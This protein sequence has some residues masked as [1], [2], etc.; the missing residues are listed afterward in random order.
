VL[1]VVGVVGAYLPFVPEFRLEPELVLV[2]LLPPLLYATAIRTSLVDFKA[3]RRA[4]ALLSVGLVVFTTVVVGLVAYWIVPGAFPLAAALALGAVV[5]PPDAVAATAVGRRVG[6]PR[7]LVSLLEGESL[8]NDATALVALNTAIAALVLSVT[9]AEVAQDFFVAAVGGL[10]AGLLV[11]Y[12]FALVRRR[13][14]DPVLDTV[15]SLVAPF[16]AFLAAETVHGSGV[17]AV[18]MTGVFLAHKSH[19]LQS[20]ASRLSESNIWRTVQFLLENTVFL[21][22]GLQ[23]P[24]VLEQARGAV[25]DGQLVL[26]CTV[27]LLAVLV[28]RPV[29]V[30]ALVGLYRL[31]ARRWDV[32]VWSPQYAAVVSW[33]GMRGVVSLAAVFALP[34]STPQRGVLLLAAFVVVVGTL[35]LQGLTLPALVRRMGLPSPDPA[36]DALQEAALMS[37]VMSAGQDRLTRERAPHDP[38]DVIERLV[39]RSR[40]RSDVAWERLGRANSEYEPPTA[41]YIRLRLAMLE[42]ERAAVVAARDAGRYDNE[43]L[44]SA[45]TVLDIEESLLDRRELESAESADRLPAARSVGDCEHLREAP[46]LARPRTPE[47]CEECLAEGTDWVHLRLCLTCGQVGCCDS[48][49]RKHADQH[50]AQTGHPVMRSFEPREA[51]R[52]CYPDQ[53][54]G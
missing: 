48:S 24:Y 20:G 50:F 41:A 11:A 27:L 40:G 16:V 44:R 9:P 47:G 34:E 29:Y 46:T 28:A 3:D 26:I 21:L 25:S 37:E 31:A 18:V 42:S 8:L 5:A 53:L 19:L 35:L 49:V 7:R 6:M 13:V 33:A 54:V 32:E 12:L 38:P 43:V 52:W 45:Q 1:V 23:L 15:L 14:D 36:E 22:I 2:G 10:G 4:I 30:F 39:A 17:L 51:W